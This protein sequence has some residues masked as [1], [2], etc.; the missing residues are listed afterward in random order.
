VKD[1]PIVKLL[2]KFNENV[3]IYLISY[4]YRFEVEDITEEKIT[5]VTECLLRLF[6]ILE[7]VEA[8]YSS[9]KFKTFLFG[10]NIKLVNE[11]INNEEIERDFNEHISRQFDR[12]D[13]ENRLLDYDKNI[14]VYLNE[15]LYAKAHELA[16]NFSETV[17]IEHIM[18]AS[19]HNIETIRQDAGIESKEEFDGIANKLGNKILLEDYI[20]SSISNDWFKTKKQKS[21][22]DKSGYKDSKYNI[23][24]ALTLYPKDTWTKTDIDDATAKVA[25]RIS[26]F[27]FGE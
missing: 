10:E 8:G 25:I 26:N 12:R 21:I 6:A 2:Q 3:K 4:L 1:Y 7:L 15:Y 17:T 27:I 13:I 14:L 20:N 22:N 19:G 18:P 23:A 24:F 11:A 5:K 16:F 9:S